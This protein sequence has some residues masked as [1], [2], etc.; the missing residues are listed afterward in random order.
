MSNPQSA[1]CNRESQILYRPA[2][3]S[4]QKTIRAIIREAGINPLRWQWS[5]FLLAANAITSEVVGTGQ[6]KTHGDSSRELAS[7]VVRPAHQRR[8][9][10][11]EMV[12]R[13]IAQD[14]RESNAP[15][16]LLCA[17]NMLAFYERFGSRRV[18]RSETPPYFYFRP[19][20]APGGL[21]GGFPARRPDC[22][23]VTVLSAEDKRAYAG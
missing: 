17:G 4:D 14:A 11:S 13:M 22:P 10:A 20:D 16:Y 21:C 8:R 5:N 3:A 6:I 12:R 15:L 9:I 19:P 7:I 2:T 18:E 1:I 23:V